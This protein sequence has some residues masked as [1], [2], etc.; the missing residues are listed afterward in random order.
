MSHLKRI[1]SS[2]LFRWAEN[3]SE[4]DISSKVL[5]LRQTGNSNDFS[6]PSVIQQL[7]Y[8][9]AHVP[10]YRELFSLHKISVDKIERD[11]DFFQ[12]VPML[13]KEII[14]ERGSDLISVEYADHFL[15]Q[16]RTNGSTGSNLSVFYSQGDLD[17]TAA[18]NQICYDFCRRSVDQKEVH[19][20]ADLRP[21]SVNLSRWAHGRVKQLAMNRANVFISGLDSRG[22]EQLYSDLLNAR[23]VL[24]QGHPSTIYHLANYIAE[25]LKHPLRL[26]QKFAS[27]GETLQPYMAERI[28][29]WIGCEIFNRYGSAE[30]GVIAHSTDNYEELEIINHLAYVENYLPNS[31]QCELLVTSLK[32]R[33]MPYIRYQTGDLGEVFERKEKVLIRQLHGR[34]HDF[35]I[36]EDNIYPS[37]FIQDVLTKN[38]ELIDFQV[39]VDS[40]SCFLAFELCTTADISH[41]KR[42]ELLYEID[43]HFG[44]GLKITFTEASKLK[45]VGWLGKFKHVVKDSD[46]YE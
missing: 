44:T 45:R 39:L 41:E 8:S 18:A 30:F 14:L 38:D 33:A 5:A 23:P 34:V 27:T 35:V 26:F 31:A 12:D 16:R 2:M 20:A 46:A 21:T 32:N 42:E 25:K 15:H 13:T 29:Q 22:T 4:R 28:K 10:Y 1:A 19:I 36:F 40:G 7:R 9:E 17:W 24:V 43:Q 37:H 11:F 3:F 6:R